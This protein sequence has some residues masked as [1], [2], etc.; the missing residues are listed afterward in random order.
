M[1]EFVTAEAARER[2][3]ELADQVDA[4]YA[5]MRTLSSDGVGSEFRVKSA[6]R[7]ETQ[8]RINRGLSYR[9][10]GEVADPPDETAMAPI[11]AVSYT[12]LTLPTN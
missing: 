11:V 3:R 1:G 2:F 7:L 12:H 6:E 8:E 10:F 5:E 4:A 9:M